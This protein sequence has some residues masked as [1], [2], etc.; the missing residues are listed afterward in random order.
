MFICHLCSPFWK[1]LKWA[2]NIFI[3]FRHDSKGIILITHWTL[4]FPLCY[5]FGILL[6]LRKII[7]NSLMTVCTAILTLLH[8]LEYVK[9]S[10]NN[11][12]FFTSKYSIATWMEVWRR[13]QKMLRLCLRAQMT[14]S[15]CVEGCS[16]IQNHIWMNH[17]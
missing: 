3:T 11:F 2:Y 9:L 5:F 4:S 8:C 15:N 14:N 10:L 12:Q 6:Y 16:A 17:D 13:S 7:V 1:C